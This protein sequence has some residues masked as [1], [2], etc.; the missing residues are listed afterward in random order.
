LTYQWWWVNKLERW[1][2]DCQFLEVGILQIEQAS[3]S[4]LH[5]FWFK[6]FI[7][8]PSWV[9]ATLVLKRR[10][11]SGLTWLDPMANKITDYTWSI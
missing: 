3:D 2:D 7:P 9:H 6:I 5:F 4:A 10:V 1:L 11:H 8:H